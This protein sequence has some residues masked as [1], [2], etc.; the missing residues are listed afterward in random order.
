MSFFYFS[1]EL[2][3]WAGKST[4]KLHPS[5]SDFGCCAWG[6]IILLSLFLF[7]ILS[8]V[9][10]PLKLPSKFNLHPQC[11][12]RPWMNLERANNSGELCAPLVIN[13]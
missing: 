1:Y 13:V 9:T 12:T 11:L 4:V 10:S 3:F 7:V 8:P 5:L 2:N 6:Q